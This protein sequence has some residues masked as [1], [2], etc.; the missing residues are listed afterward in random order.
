MYAFMILHQSRRQFWFQN[1][2][3]VTFSTSRGKMVMLLVTA[4]LD[5]DQEFLL[6]IP[7]KDE[8]NKGCCY[9]NH[10]D[11]V[12]CDA[13]HSNSPQSTYSRLH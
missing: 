7:T 2:R 1:T 11:A 13:D 5:C 8:D 10:C 12:L 4:L 9:C 3:A 6:S